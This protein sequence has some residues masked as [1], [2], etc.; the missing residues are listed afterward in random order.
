M[1]DQSSPPISTPL[2]GVLSRCF[3]ASILI[4]PIAASVYAGM[5]F[6]AGAEPNWDMLG[7]GYSIWFIWIVIWIVF[8]SE[9][10]PGIGR[11]YDYGFLVYA[12]FAVYVPYYLFKTRGWW[13]LPML[14]GL[15]ILFL[16]PGLTLWAIWA[17]QSFA[18]SLAG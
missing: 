10:R 8:D 5:V 11:P 12:F 15:L 6:L 7:L 3:L 14:L 9:G 16:A 17:I 18:Y 4:L 1:N 2:R 13:A